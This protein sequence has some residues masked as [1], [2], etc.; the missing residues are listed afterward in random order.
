M[1]PLKFLAL[2]I[3]FLGLSLPAF[4]S[5]GT[6]VVGDTVTISVTSDGDPPLT[7]QWKRGGVNTGITSQAFTLAPVALADAGIYTVMVSNSADS[8]LSDT[9]TLTVNP[10]VAPPTHATTS[11]VVTKKTDT[12]PG[13]LPGTAGH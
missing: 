8:V 2:F 6:A 10:P 13:T 3:L 4:A 1:K 9:A 7:Y 12:P 5:T 11:T